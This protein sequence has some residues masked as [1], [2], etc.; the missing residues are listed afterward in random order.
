MVLCFPSL[1]G[2]WAL[3]AHSRIR[4]AFPGPGLP[5]EEMG[6]RAPP[7]P[8]ISEDTDA[9][10]WPLTAAWYQKIENKGRI[11]AYLPPCGCEPEGWAGEEANGPRYL[12]VKYKLPSGYIK[13]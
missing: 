4:D 3:G 9:V 1:P 8:R 12:S 6:S 10:L 5:L 2:L 7:L 13:S 11:E